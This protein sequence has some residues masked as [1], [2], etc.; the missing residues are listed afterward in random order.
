MIGFHQDRDVFFGKYLRGPCTGRDGNQ[1]DGEGIQNLESQPDPRGESTPINATRLLLPGLMHGYWPSRAELVFESV[2]SS[3][4]YRNS[5]RKNIP[6]SEE[7]DQCQE[8]AFEYQRSDRS[9]VYDRSKL[10]PAAI[11]VKRYRIPAGGMSRL[12]RGEKEVCRD[13]YIRTTVVEWDK[14]DIF[15]LTSVSCELVGLDQPRSGFGLLSGAPLILNLDHT[16]N[17]SRKWQ[18][19]LSE[20][21]ENLTPSRIESREDFG[22]CASSTKL[23]NVRVAGYRPGNASDGH[24]MARCQTTL[25]LLPPDHGQLP[26]S[27][28]IAH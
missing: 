13:E 19:T 2:Q 5:A 22:E 25:H 20:D 18:N 7:R 11:S 17:T 8:I 3:A 9:E 10:M 28:L 4:Y 27:K 24:H 16:S 26:P 12:P 21:K 1:M 6:P 14:G 15:A 23:F